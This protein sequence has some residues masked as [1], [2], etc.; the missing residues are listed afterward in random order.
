MSWKM[1]DPYYLKVDYHSLN[2]TLGSKSS[3]SALVTPSF[4]RKHGG[5][6][7]QRNMYFFKGQIKSI[8]LLY[9]REKV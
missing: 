4:C 7:A 8:V 3:Y 5:I 2:R 1:K 6:M 9:Q